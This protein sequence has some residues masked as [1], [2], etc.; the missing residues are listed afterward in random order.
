[1]AKKKVDLKSA[2][3]NEDPNTN[4]QTIYQSPGQVGPDIYK[5]APKAGEVI[6]DPS[7]GYS[8]I[9]YDDPDYLAKVKKMRSGGS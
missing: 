8:V 9:D 5:P 3:S 2:L 1:M 7:G 6:H 4:S